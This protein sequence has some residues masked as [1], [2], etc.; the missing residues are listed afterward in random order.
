MVTKS[1]TFFQIEKL[2]LE[3]HNEQMYKHF[4]ITLLLMVSERDMTF[5]VLL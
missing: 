4:F 2:G 5:G 3:N 1:Q